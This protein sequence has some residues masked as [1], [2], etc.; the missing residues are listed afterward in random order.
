M[1]NSAKT[2]RRR[3][4]AQEAQKREGSRSAHQ[5]DPVD[6]SGP[7]TDEDEEEDREVLFVP[8]SEREEES[9]QVPTTVQASSDCE[10]MNMVKTLNGAIA[11]VSQDTVRIRRAYDQLRA[12]NITRDKALADISA[13]GEGVWPY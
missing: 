12:D 3:K 7:V 8:R 1:V 2:A 5:M 6:L 13:I 9:P 11:S 4:L 10:I